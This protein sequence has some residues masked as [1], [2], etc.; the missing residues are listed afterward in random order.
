MVDEQATSQLKGLEE[1]PSLPFVD[2][3]SIGNYYYVRECYDEYYKLVKDMLD[4]KD[5]CIT[6]TGTP[7]IGK[8]IFYAYFFQRFRKE[9]K[10]NDMWIIAAAYRGAEL[11]AAIGYKDN[12]DDAKE[13]LSDEEIN[14]FIRAAWK[15]KKSVI[16]L[17]DGPP[18]R[19]RGWTQTVV[20]TSPNER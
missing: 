3:Y 13:I 18:N 12:D 17:C 9:M 4:D 11:N 8:S 7:G 5:D 16:L 1:L 6:V 2:K 20:F 14:D 10:G 19:T 15:K